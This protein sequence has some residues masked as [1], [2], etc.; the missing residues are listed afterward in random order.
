PQQQAV[1]PP[2]LIQQPSQPNAQQADLMKTYVNTGRPD[3]KM[4]FRSNGPPHESFDRN[5][6]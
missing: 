4:D 6:L 5:R 3:V 2:V 1:P